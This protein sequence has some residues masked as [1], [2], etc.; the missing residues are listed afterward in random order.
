MENNK[1]QKVKLENI[2]NLP[3]KDKSKEK[4]SIISKTK[5]LASGSEDHQLKV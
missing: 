3:L 2:K 1:K 4:K 5:K